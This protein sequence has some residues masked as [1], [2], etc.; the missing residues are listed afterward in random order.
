MK[1]SVPAAMS[2]M[3]QNIADM[4]RRNNVNVVENGDVKVNILRGPDENVNNIEAVNGH[5]DDQ[6]EEEEEVNDAQEVGHDEGR[7]LLVSKQNVERTQWH[8]QPGFFACI[9]NTHGLAFW[10]FIRNL[11]PKSS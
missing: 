5:G 6:E 7:L 2:L 4:L 1:C 10:R 3:G 8:S 9:N 11:K